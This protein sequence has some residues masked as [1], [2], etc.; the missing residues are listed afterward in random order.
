MKKSTNSPFLTV[1]EKAV[2]K[3]TILAVLSAIVTGLINLGNQIVQTGSFEISWH[4]IAII[5]VSGL[6]TGFVYLS[7]KLLSNNQDELLKK[8]I[9]PCNKNQ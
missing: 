1:N 5:G 2:I 9:M 8:D 3:A 4:Q 6:V 7:T